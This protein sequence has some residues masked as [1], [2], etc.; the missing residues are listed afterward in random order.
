MGSVGG[1]KAR[2]QYLTEDLGMLLVTPAAC[3]STVFKERKKSGLDPFFGC[4]VPG[5][6]CPA[7]H[8]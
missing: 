4:D 7:T 1:W 5:A 6:N 2:Q 3:L 8:A